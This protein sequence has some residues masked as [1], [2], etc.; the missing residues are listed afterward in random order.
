[1]QIAQNIYLYSLFTTYLDVVAWNQT[2]AMNLTMSNVLLKEKHATKSSK[3]L[4][5]KMW[6]TSCMRVLHMFGTH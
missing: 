4:C 2:V 6:C 3:K 1:M 5:G